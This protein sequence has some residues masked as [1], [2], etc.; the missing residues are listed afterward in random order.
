MSALPIPT[1]LRDGAYTLEG[2][3]GRG[4]F[5]ITY[6]ARDMRAH[7]LNAPTY[8]V[9][10]STRILAETLAC[11]VTTARDMGGADAGFREAINDGYV[12]GPRLLISIVMISQT[13]GHGDSW[14]PAGIWLQK[15]AWRRTRSVT[16]S[17]RCAKSR[18]DSGADFIKIAPA[19]ASVGYRQLG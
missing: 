13:G 6:R 15:R 7:L 14:V 11:G 17:T 4:G 12:T 1:A 8:N 5:G 10:R 16:A 3:I 2:V 9:L 18:S 19:A